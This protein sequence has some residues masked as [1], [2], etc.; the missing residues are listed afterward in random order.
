[1]NRKG[2]VYAL[3]ISLLSSAFLLT[4]T[5]GSAAADTAP[6][7]ILPPFA[8]T[9]HGS[10]II[11]DN[12]SLEV[13]E[14]GITSGSGTAAD[15][16]VIEGWEIQGD[17]EIFLT[18][19][20]I[21]VRNNYIHSSYYGIWLQS[22]TNVEISGNYVC[23]CI[24]G[25]QIW[26][27]SN[28]VVKG[29]VIF[30]NGE[31]G[32]VAISSSQEVTFSSNKLYDDG[33]YLVGWTWEDY[34][35]HTFTA[36]N[37]VNDKPLL[38]YSGM[39]GLTILAQPVGELIVVAS[40]NVRVAGLSI[41]DTDVGM[42][43]AFVDGAVVSGCSISRTWSGG[44]NLDYDTS[45]V[46][47]NCVFE[48]NYFSGTSLWGCSNSI[49]TG[50]TFEDNYYGGLV[51]MSDGISVTKNKF[52]GNGLS[53]SLDG[54]TNVVVSKNNIDDALYYGVLVADDTA[55]LSHITISGNH[56]SGC[57]LGIF[58]S[59]ASDSLLTENVVIGCDVGIEIGHVSALSVYHNS[60]IRNTVQALVEDDSSTVAWD[61]GYPNGGNYWSDS[62]G[63]DRF[64]GPMQDINGHDGI[65]DTPYVI[66]T[67]NVDRYPLIK[68]I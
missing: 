29:N 51:M 59:G 37:T 34:C 33:V 65:G 27:S 43:L 32:G 36:D 57:W 52:H 25:I 13:G 41:S 9:P 28:I 14:N 7:A 3:A 49:V 31:L 24:S 45:V 1:M 26:T 44:I 54:S 19:Q 15:P 48:S 23:D 42:E 11:Y 68:E 53:I 47:E 12:P 46:V 50:S 39:D 58:I 22:S 30:N 55:V 35:S 38:Y 63:M 60:F 16:F 17:I 62:V 2:I 5:I 20:H 40:K 67:M 56:V 18:T 8:T 4:G 66:D 10:I 61:N 6:A 64:R 21:A